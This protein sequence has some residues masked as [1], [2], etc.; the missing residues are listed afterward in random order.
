MKALLR[1]SLLFC[2]S[3]LLLFCSEELMVMWHRIASA[4][5][6]WRF[7]A[8]V[9]MAVLLPLTSVSA[10]SCIGPDPKAEWHQRQMVK[11]SKLR[12]ASA[13]GFTP[14]ERLTPVLVRDDSLCARALAAHNHRLAAAALR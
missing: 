9:T 10:Q 4:P 7:V 2:S 5:E 1:G 6:L 12:D 13:L 11:L 14:G 3:A 8:P